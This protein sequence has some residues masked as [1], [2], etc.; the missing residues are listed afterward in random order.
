MNVNELFGPTIQGE[1]KYTGY[2]SVFLRLNG[3]NLRCA[4]AGGSIC[5]TPYTSHHPESGLNRNVKDVADSIIDL[6][7]ET[8]QP[9]KC[10]LVI[11]GGEPMLQKDEIA[12]LVWEI[13]E[14]GYH[15]VI[16]IETNGTIMPN[17]DLECR[18]FWSISPKL[19]TSCQ[20][21]GTDVPK[22]LQLAHERNRIQIRALD[23][24]TRTSNYQLKFV[25]SGPD[26]VKEIKSIIDTLVETKAHNGIHIR[27]EDFNILLMPEGINVEQLDKHAKECVQACIENGWIFC[28][29]EHIRIWG[30]KR[31]V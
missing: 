11:T 23:H 17:Y 30:D 12:D 31:A 28:D 5:D 20:F 26:S 22:T 25:Y 9:Y 6:F 19:K 15:P 2:P 21:E 18:V 1:G 13:H 24:L 27:P 4:F 8:G 14:R 10:H 16:T 29:R 7:N 3:C